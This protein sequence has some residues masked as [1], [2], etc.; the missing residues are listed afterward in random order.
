MSGI[1]RNKCYEMSSLEHVSVSYCG[2]KLN[3]AVWITETKQ[4][5]CLHGEQMMTRCISAGKSDREHGLLDSS[6][7]ALQLPLSKEALLLKSYMK[8]CTFCPLWNFACCPNG[9]A[10][11]ITELVKMLLTLFFVSLI[12]SGWTC[13]FYWQF[14]VM[15][16]VVPL[17]V[18]GLFSTKC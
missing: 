14:Q 15:S 18:K 12:K 3:R 2:D 7:T 6:K 1:V 8:C 10:K 9:I 17:Q 13:L 16:Q 5:T 4:A 11:G